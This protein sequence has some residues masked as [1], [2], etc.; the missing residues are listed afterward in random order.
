MLTKQGAAKDS[1]DGEGFNK[2]SRAHQVAKGSAVG[3]GLNGWPTTQQVVN[4]FSGNYENAN[5]GL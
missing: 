4:P 5:N 3:Q 1:M 2:W